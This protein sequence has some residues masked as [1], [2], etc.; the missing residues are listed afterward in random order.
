MALP[1]LAQLLRRHIPH[2]HFGIHLELPC[3][4]VASHQPVRLE[5]TDTER[6]QLF[7]WE[8]ALGRSVLEVG[9]VEP[10]QSWDNDSVPS[11]SVDGL[12]VDDGRSLQCSAR[13]LEH[14][15]QT[16]GIHHQPAQSKSLLADSCVAFDMLL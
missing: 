11:R 8:P 9:Q 4:Y 5:C 15:L 6:S 12:A 7:E 13:S 2:S 14:W 16:V 1:G 10:P 3:S